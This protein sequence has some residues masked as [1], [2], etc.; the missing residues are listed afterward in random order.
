[1]SR[2]AL[3]LR[4]LVEPPDGVS[5]YV[6]ELLRRLPDLLPRDDIF[7]VG[8]PERIRRHSARPLTLEACTRTVSL[9]EQLELPWILLRNKIDLFHGTMFVAPRVPCCPYLLTLHDLNYLAV[10]ELYPTRRRLYLTTLVEH[11]APRAQAILTVSEFSR[12]EIERCLEIPGERIEVVPN[13][14]D[15]SFRPQEERTIP[16]VRERWSLPAEYLL[17]VGSLAPHKNVPF[18]LRA[19]ARLK[20]V[21]PLV[22]CGP[23]MDKAVRQT[24]S[25]R[26]IT[27]PGQGH[28]VLPALLSGATAFIFPSRYEGFGLPPL[29]AMACGAPTIVSDAASLPEVT[30]GAAL[31]YPV[32]D[33][34]ALSDRILEVV[35]S[36]ELRYRLARAGPVQAAH[37]R[38]EDCARRMAKI[39]RR[40]L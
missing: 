23:S 1:M 26:V 13:G 5:R 9:R 35:G 14:I 2:I 21:P 33:E 30:G 25:A 29:E 17:Y 28:D 40:Y 38:W 15:D 36:S 7:A 39:Y 4:M 6:L 10:P 32:D 19:Y 3:D 34:R 27:I 22:L 31:V 12:R 18:L 37:F 11:L 20:D 24:Q 8:S 16:A